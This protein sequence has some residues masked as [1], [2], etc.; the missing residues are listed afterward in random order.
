LQRGL[1]ERTTEAALRSPGRFLL[2][3]GLLAAISIWLASGLEV[4]SSFEELL[5]SDVP[6]VAHVKELIRRV[7]GDGTVLVVIE[8][9][10]PLHGLAP[11]E[12]LATKLAREFLGLGPGTIRS[13]EWNM[14]PIQAWYADHWPMF[15]SFVDLEK[16]RDTIRAEVAKAKVRAN[17]LDLH[18]EDEPEPPSPAPEALPWL[19]PSRPLPRRQVEERFARY[20]DGFLVHPDGWSL[21][22]VVRPTGTALGVHEARALL[23]HLKAVV[24]THQSE[25]QAHHLR[26]GFGGTFPLFVAEYEAIL[27]DV[28]STALIVLSLVLGSLFL[29]YRELRSTIS[30]G[31]A[32]LLAVAVTFGLTR[33]VIGYLNTQ[34]AFLGAI[35]VGNGINYGLIYLARVK[36]LRRAGVALQPACIDGARTSARATL[37]ASAASSVSFGILVLAANRGFRHFGFIGGVGMLLCWISTF[38]LVPALL[39]VFER[40]HPVTPDKRVQSAGSRD[41]AFLKR[42]FSHPRVI[43][44]VFVTLG[45]VAAAL[46][47]R[48]LPEALE[49]NLT[50]LTNELRRENELLRDNDRAQASLGKSIAGAIALLPS[51]AEAEAFCE[52]IR[53]RQAQPRWSMLIDGCETISSVVPQQQRQKL[54]LIGEIVRQLSDLVLDELPAPQAKRMREVRAQLAAQRILTVEM[55]PPSLV[56][57]F[58]ERDGTIGRIAVITAKPDAQLELGPN[59]QNFADGVR[60]VPVDEHLYDAAGENVVFADLLRN[61]EREGPLTTLLSLLGV[62]LLVIALFRSVRASALVIVTLVLGVILM[63]GVAALIGLK[64]N[65]FNFIVYP[66]TFGIAVDYGANVVTR[67][68]ERGGD[69]LGSLAE[70]GPAVALCSWTSIIGYASLLPALNRALRS[71]GWYGAIGEVTSIVC[72]LVFLPALRLLVPPKVVEVKKGPV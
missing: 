60:N 49:R 61:I 68:R 20:M 5:P 70:V 33:L 51:A 67:I 36:Q 2:V 48:Q 65:F 30:L 57:R 63:A 1:I 14:K 29:F 62:C 54:A 15:V 58:R 8:M 34:T 40:L 39:A 31:I 17:P 28:L 10:D 27:N 32:V 4:R 3:A 24:D 66:I 64:I 12:E 44:V 16:A 47:L 72:A 6:S 11:A 45:A 26:V 41:H 21:T 9:L 50:N 18:L 52:V 59:L 35:V 22:L 43:V 56:D 38:A 23:N 13:L 69:V 7:G 46:F 55:A 19:D 25:L 71:F 37:V 42:A 53:L